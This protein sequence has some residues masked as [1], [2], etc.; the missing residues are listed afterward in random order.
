MTPI[1]EK[2]VKSYQSLL[3][4]NA[5]LK[6]EGQK[7]L[8]SNRELELKNRRMYNAGRE[9]TDAL[10]KHFYSYELP[11]DLNDALD[12]MLDSLDKNNQ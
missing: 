3:D 4:E 11:K 7:L 6:N 1:I 8:D 12:A 2:V 9:L 5:T 10:N